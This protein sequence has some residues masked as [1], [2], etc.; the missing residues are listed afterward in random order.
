MSEM[1]RAEGWE[2]DNLGL[3]LC[4]ATSTMNLNLPSNVC[5]SICE[6]GTVLPLSQVS[7]RSQEATCNKPTAPMAV[8]G[9]GAAAG[10]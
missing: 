3:C 10:P 4:C 2:S 9:G 1:Q 7:V 8:K 6:L 5:E